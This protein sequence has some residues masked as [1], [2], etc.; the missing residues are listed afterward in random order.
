MEE[1]QW[2]VVETAVRRWPDEIRGV[3]YRKMRA[4]V[5]ADAANEY[6]AAGDLVTARRRMAA[7]LLAW[8]F[9]R[10]RLRVMASL[11]VKAAIAVIRNRGTTATNRQ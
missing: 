4:L 9:H 10:R 3:T 7:A 5:L 8:P 11:S 2:Q 1:S 6:I